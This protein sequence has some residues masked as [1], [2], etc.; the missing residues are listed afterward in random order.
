[1][2]VDS[3]MIII[4]SCSI[5]S[6]PPTTNLTWAWANSTLTMGA[7]LVFNSLAFT[8]NADATAWKLT[9][10]GAY[11]ITIA[12]L[13]F[14]TITNGQS[15]GQLTFPT[16]YS[17][18]VTSLLGSSLTGTGATIASSSNSTT[19]Y[20][21]YTGLVDP[22]LVNINFT[23]CDA[24]GS[25]NLPIYVWKGTLTSCVNMIVPNPASAFSGCSITLAHF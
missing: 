22:F 23:R 14:G 19:F 9:F 16:G 5:N 2:G 6:L 13:Y 11:D 12:E 1:M 7:S 10:S 17:I 18:N 25:R 21:N 15:S 20:L 8:Y 3:Q 4:G 24:T